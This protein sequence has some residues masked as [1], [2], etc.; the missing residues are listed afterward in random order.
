MLELHTVNRNSV[1]F[2]NSVT[3]Y[4]IKSVIVFTDASLYPILGLAVLGKCLLVGILAV[5]VLCHFGLNFNESLA[6]IGLTRLSSKFRHQLL[7]L[8]VLNNRLNGV[9]HSLCDCKGILVVLVDFLIRQCNIK[10]TKITAVLDCVCKCLQFGSSLA[11][12]NFL[13]ALCRRRVLSVISI[14]LTPAH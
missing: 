7:F 2:L 12:L 14:E 10:V 8:H 4:K 1:I 9:A 5:L 3:A 13:I 6:K 11:C